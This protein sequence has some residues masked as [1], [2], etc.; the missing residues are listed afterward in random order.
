MRRFPR[1]ACPDLL[2]ISAP[3]CAERICT[4]EEEKSDEYRLQKWNNPKPAH[5]RSIPE[6][7]RARIALGDWRILS[8]E[9]LNEQ[10]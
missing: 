9:R 7:H 10:S 4:G 5:E 6:M 3:A 1:H 2:A 8:I